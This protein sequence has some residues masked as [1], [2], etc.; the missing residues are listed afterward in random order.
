MLLA[1][2]FSEWTFLLKS[3]TSYATASYAPL[4]VQEECCIID[5]IHKDGSI[6][7][8]PPKITLHRTVHVS[9]LSQF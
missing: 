3:N 8:F 9:R 2:Q 4:T 7:A 5:A 6:T 1:A